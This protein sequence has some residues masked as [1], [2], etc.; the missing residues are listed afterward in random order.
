MP[1][2]SPQSPTAKQSA[3]LAVYRIAE[4]SL[5]N[6]IKHSNAS[7]AVVEVQLSSKTE[8]KLLVQDDG[9]GFDLEEVTKGIGIMSM[10]DYADYMVAG[11]GLSV[12]WGK[13]PR[14]G[15]LFHSTA[16]STAWLKGASRSK[17]SLFE[18]V[19]F[20]VQQLHRSEG[21]WERYQSR[22]NQC[23]PPVSSSLR[24]SVT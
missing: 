5:T 23:D 15:L 12:N 3:R 6:L 19:E 18:I 8:L 16:R 21:L 14:L 7:R 22:S 9:K 2:T 24:S 10:P 20:C 11:I 17:R 4:D 13:G 1:A